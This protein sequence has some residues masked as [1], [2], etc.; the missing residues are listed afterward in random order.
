MK[1]QLLFLF[2]IFSEC[3]VSSIYS[4]NG[5]SKSELKFEVASGLN[6]TSIKQIENSNSA[7]PFLGIQLQM[8]FYNEFSLK[9]GAEF[10]YFDFSNFTAYPKI[11]NSYL[12]LK[13]IPQVRIA[14]FAKFGAGLQY[15]FLLKSSV[16]TLG[17]SYN[18]ATMYQFESDFTSTLDYVIGF[19]ID[20]YRRVSMGLN[21]S[22]SLTDPSYALRTFKVSVNYNVLGKSEKRPSAKAIARQQ[23]QDL[24]NGVLLVRLQTSKTKID[25]LRSAGHQKKAIEAEQAQFAENQ[26]IMKAFSENFSFC[27]VYFFTSDKTLQVKNRIFSNVFVDSTLQIDS[28]ISLPQDIKIFFAEFGTI[29]DDENYGK[30]GYRYQNPANMREKIPS[31]Q[32]GAEIQFSALVVYDSNFVQLKRPFPYYVR[33]HFKSIKKHPEMMLFMFPYVLD[34]NIWSFADVVEKMNNKLLKFLD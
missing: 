30:T 5:Q 2:L 26:K 20:L 13:L 12:Q 29:G 18:N 22:A 10:A 28:T 11:R 16:L 25:A 27:P 1:T 34:S 17:E 8:P 6:F 33:S 4:Q 24:R 14:N 3:F 19:D 21:A 23:I 31:F 32:G 7:K 9:S 15:S